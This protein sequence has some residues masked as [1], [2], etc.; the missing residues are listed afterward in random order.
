MVAGM[1][2]A[3][4]VL[5]RAPAFTAAL[6]HASHRWAE[7]GGLLVV[8]SREAAAEA[9]RDAAADSATVGRDAITFAALRG[10]VAHALGEA[11][12]RIPS[13]IA[14]RLALRDVLATVDLTAFGGSARTPGFLGAMERAVG[15]LREAGV[16]PERAVLA[17][18]GPVATAVAAVHAASWDAVPHPSDALWHVAEAAVRLA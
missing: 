8:P 14:T 10:R 1:A 7:V 13:P 17:A 2:E 11:E 3:T 18:Q 4:L 5:T 12:P 16:A 6:V 15:E 9:L